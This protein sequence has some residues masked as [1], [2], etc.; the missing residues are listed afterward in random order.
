LTF[1][2]R[3][4]IGLFYCLGFLLLALQV[5][6]VKKVVLEKTIEY[7]LDEPHHSVLVEGARG[8]FPFSLTVSKCSIKDEAGP[9]LVLDNIDISLRPFPLKIIFFNTESLTFNHVPK[10]E[11]PTVI[12]LAALLSQTIVQSLKIDRILID[13]QVLG[14]EY[15]ASLQLRPTSEGGQDLELTS[16]VAGKIST[17]FRSAVKNYKDGVSVYFKGSDAHGG[18]F[19]ALLSQKTSIPQ[20][21]ISL[22][23]NFKTQSLRMNADSNFDLR[24]NHTQFGGAQIQA[25]QKIGIA[26]VKATVS[27]LNQSPYTLDA[28]IDNTTGNAFTVTFFKLFQEE[29]GSLQGDMLVTPKALSGNLNVKANMSISTGD[30][31]DLL[32]SFSAHVD[33]NLSQKVLKCRGS[34]THLPALSPSM[35]DVLGETLEWS[36]TVDYH[37][38]ET[39]IFEKITLS[40][41]KGH[42]LGGDIQILPTELKGKLTTSLS[43]QAALQGK[44]DPILIETTLSG[45]L[46]AWLVSLKAEGSGNRINAKMHYYPKTSTFDLN[47]VGD[48]AKLGFSDDLSSPLHF[49]AKLDQSLSGQITGLI[50]DLKLGDLYFSAANLSIDLNQG[51]GTYDLKATGRKRLKNNKPPLQV[52]SSKGDLDFSKQTLLVKDLKFT[53]DNH[54]IE[55]QQPCGF[56]F[57]ERKADPLS[58][59]LDKGKLKTSALNL[60]A[61]WKGHIV[62]EAIP[63]SLTHLLDNK[64]SLHGLLSGEVNLNGDQS[65]PHLVG[66][67]DIEGLSH[68]SEEKEFKTNVQTTFDWGPEV[69]KWTL[70]CQGGASLTL[71]S[72]GKITVQNGYIQ[73]TSVIQSTIEGDSYL[74]ALAAFLADEDRI[75]G[76]LKTNLKVSGTAEKP[77]LDGTLTINNGLY[78]IGEFGTLIR[79]IELTAETKGSDLCIT[80]LTA[81]DGNSHSKEK[82]VLTGSGKVRFTS[83]LS[84][85]IDIELILH[86]FKIA[87]SDSFVS[88]ASGDLFLKGEGAKAKVTGDVTLDSADLFLEEVATKDPPTIHMTNQSLQVGP[89]D[90]DSTPV[91]VLPIDLKL[92]TDTFNII[93]F[94]LESHW[95]GNMTV[96]GSLLDSQLLGEIRIEKGKLDIFGK[97]LKISEGRIIYDTIQRNEPLLFMKASRAADSE[98]T[99]TLVIEG[100]AED[101][102]FTFTSDPPYTE[103]EILSRLLFGKELGKIS[104]GQSLQL[105]SAAATMNGQKG[106][107]I[108]DK[109]RSSF[110]LDTLELKDN[111]SSDDYGSS[112]GQA[113]SIGK[114]LNENVK[115][116]IDQ[117]VS[118]GSSKATV[119]VGVANNVNVSA[120][121]GGDKSSGIGLSWVKRY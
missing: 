114:E 20:G 50:K 70:R 103:E 98:T 17:T 102:H 75:N 34:T 104:V 1:F 107:N 105:A 60:S 118:T 86:H 4:L 88:T 95:R 69:L 15:Q 71:S 115:I 36:T 43:A 10:L 100:R 84:P 73:P 32:A 110:G 7:V 25:D 40:T 90:K 27:L 23:G 54:K 74:G 52:L 47:M 63:L 59:T 38:P 18:L 29:K 16:S 91:N 35:K 116:S 44:Q 108:T 97:A 8:F 49:E 3:T 39:V 6:F 111:K 80:S 42:H 106:L 5:P 31:E 85:H 77:H 56:D 119:E 53:P 96:V 109:I 89:K 94:G 99:I 28:T 2:K 113:L 41:N 22:E 51:K 62:L 83:L 46:S 9:W 121:V 13:P 12:P 65:F 67:M 81:N 14:Q 66:K 37:T 93:G 92:T 19:S 30:K 57:R 78:E 61:P 117:G 11:T 48:L 64:N 68:S 33:V 26:T 58:L 24:F 55:L 101:P 120:D 21:E 87:Q 72:D 45:P 112:G 76:L 79:D 82:G